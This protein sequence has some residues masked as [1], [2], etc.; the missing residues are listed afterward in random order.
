[1]GMGRSMV[2]DKDNNCTSKYYE[3]LQQLLRDPY[4]FRVVLTNAYQLALAHFYCHY[5]HE[6]AN[7]SYRVSDPY[8]LL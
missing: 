2:V 1:M 4:N 5:L 6:K 7:Y 8:L 3:V